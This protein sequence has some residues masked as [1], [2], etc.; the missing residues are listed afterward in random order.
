M[1]SDWWNKALAAQV[2]K[3]Q[4]RIRELEKQVERLRA[5]RE[6]ILKSFRLKVEECAGALKE[7]E[8]LRAALQSIASN[9]CCDGCQ[10]AARVAAKA[11]RGSDLDAQGP[12][13]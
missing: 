1:P 13:A 4:L 12:G 7:N 3:P 2:G 8:R 10:E 9:T 5:E 11:L 6:E